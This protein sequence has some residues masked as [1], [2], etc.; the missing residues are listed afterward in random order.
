[1][2]RRPVARVTTGVAVGVV[3]LTSVFAGTAWAPKALTVR[4]HLSMEQCRHE[5]GWQSPELDFD[6]LK[7]CLVAARI[8]TKAAK[9]EAK[10]FW[11]ANR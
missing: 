5:P 2:R 6:T 9:A 8:D 10:E 4:A 1:M 11:K 7:E 3:A